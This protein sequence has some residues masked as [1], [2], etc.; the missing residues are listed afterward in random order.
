MTQH[1]VNQTPQLYPSIAGAG[2]NPLTLQF[3]S[4]DM[5]KAY[6]RSNALYQQKQLRWVALLVAGLFGLFISTDFL[7][8]PGSFE[9][10]IPW[11]EILSFPFCCPE[12]QR[13]N[14]EYPFQ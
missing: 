12:R 5:E 4:D 7:L 11:Y 9:I 1:M 8:A 6:R 14:R 13:R 2:L 3:L 10:P